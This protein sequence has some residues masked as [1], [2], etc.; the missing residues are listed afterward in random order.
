M[1]SL[2]QL[3]EDDAKLVQDQ[4]K[5]IY[6]HIGVLQLVSTLLIGIIIYQWR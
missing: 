2:R 6:Y 4:I 1:K 5:I 3:I